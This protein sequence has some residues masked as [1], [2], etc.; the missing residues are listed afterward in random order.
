MNVQTKTLSFDAMNA[1]SETASHMLKAIANPQRL[2]IL[3]LLVEGE[4]TV[5]QLNE[6]VALSQS[7]LSQHLAVLRQKS[8]VA[9]RKQAQ[10]VYYR[11]S[12]GPIRQIIQVL[13]DIYC[14]GSAEAGG[15]QQKHCD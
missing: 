13:H 3:C 10:T 2:R 9:T 1:Q 14:T 15:D 11:V 4:C 8:L 12:D 7:A 6:Q 5:S